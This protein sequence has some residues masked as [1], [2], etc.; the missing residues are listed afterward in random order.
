L[1]ADYRA[2]PEG[3]KGG[4]ERGKTDHDLPGAAPPS[5][6]NKEEKKREPRE[7]RLGK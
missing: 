4:L 7:K 6:A 1:E 2:C 5:S 3:K